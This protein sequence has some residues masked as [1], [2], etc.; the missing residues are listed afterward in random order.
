MIAPHRKNR[1]KKKTQGGRE[2]KRYRRRWK[3]ERFLAWLFDFEKTMVR[4]E[5]QADKHLAFPLVNCMKILLR[6]S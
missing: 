5:K 4:Q 6:Y 3:V 2:P 1:K